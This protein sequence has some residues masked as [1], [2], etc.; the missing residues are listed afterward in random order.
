MFGPVE[1]EGLD[2][3]EEQEPFAPEDARQK[4]INI[5]ERG[6]AIPPNLCSHGY[7]VLVKGRNLKRRSSLL[8][9]ARFLRNLEVIPNMPP[10][11][12]EEMPADNMSGSGSDN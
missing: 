11:K 12:E 1:Y 6:V 3:T 4:A 7:R 10:I 9:H 5:L 8:K 2:L